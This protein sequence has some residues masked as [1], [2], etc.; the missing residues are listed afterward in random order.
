[1]QLLSHYRSQSLLFFT[2][3]SSPSTLLRAKKKI[4]TKEECTSSLSSLLNDWLFLHSLT[5]INRKK[6]RYIRG[7]KTENQ[8][9]SHED[10]WG[11]DSFFFKKKRTHKGEPISSKYSVIITQ[12]PLRNRE[13]AFR[14]NNRTCV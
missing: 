7:K 12:R 8:Y 6:G 2:K 1:M 4:Y 13:G 5:Y 3:N 14:T 9:A 10:D 11:V